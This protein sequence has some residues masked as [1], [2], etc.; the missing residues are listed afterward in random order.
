MSVSPGD[1]TAI[2]SWLR[3]SLHPQ[4]V[5]LA[6]P[7]E[8]PSHAAVQEHMRPTISRVSLI[9][10]VKDH[11]A[12]TGLARPLEEYLHTP[13]DPSLLETEQEWKLIK[14]IFQDANKKHVGRNAARAL[15]EIQT[16]L[17]GLDFDEFEA[18]QAIERLP[19]NA[20]P[21]YRAIIET[22]PKA[23]RKLDFK[24]LMELSREAMTEKTSLLATLSRPSPAVALEPSKK[25]TERDAKT[26]ERKA[27]QAIE[28]AINHSFDD[29]AVYDATYK[30]LQAMSDSGGAKDTAR[31]LVR[32]IVRAIFTDKRVSDR[33]K[34][35][36]TELLSG[37]DAMASLL[38]EM[39][40]GIGLKP[41]P[42]ASDQGRAP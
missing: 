36:M 31:V 9:P 3:A 18:L 25:F 13:D 42:T 20:H 29:P 17:G 41:L 6:S 19:G 27:I 5:S 26:T 24:Q 39:R 1:K 14:N 10:R 7:L 28:A 23:V 4:Y 22:M 35:T 40:R 11:V 8:A 2:K 16:G 30:I 37:H 21:T 32:T 34:D 38:R 15:I 12:C 33:D